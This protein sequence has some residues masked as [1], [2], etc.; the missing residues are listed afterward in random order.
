MKVGTALDAEVGGLAQTELAVSPGTLSLR[1]HFSL[2]TGIVH[3]QTAFAG[4]VSGQ[5]DRKAVGIVKL[6]HRLAGDNRAK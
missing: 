5:I 6:E 1:C 4:D 3:L 2:E